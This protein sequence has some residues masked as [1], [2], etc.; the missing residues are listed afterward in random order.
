MG[1][2]ITAKKTLW[3][4]EEKNPPVTRL[5]PALNGSKDVKQQSVVLFL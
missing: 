3:E 4:E 2:A 1:K 5:H